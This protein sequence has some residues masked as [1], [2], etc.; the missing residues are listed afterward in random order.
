MELVEDKV[1]STLIDTTPIT[2]SEAISTLSAS[3]PDRHIGVRSLVAPH[4]CGLK[5]QW[6]SS[7]PPLW[8]IF[9]EWLSPIALSVAVVAVGVLAATY[10]SAMSE[11][12]FGVGWAALAVTLG[13][14]FLAPDTWRAIVAS[15]RST[16]TSDAQEEYE[17]H[18]HVERSSPIWLPRRIRDLLMFGWAFVVAAMVVRIL[19]DIY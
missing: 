19:I 5:Q 18:L 13:A 2:R 15:F 6:H 16:T 17:K 9:L 4:A 7:D 14:I 8:W 11:T 3:I 12:V 10:P 1:R